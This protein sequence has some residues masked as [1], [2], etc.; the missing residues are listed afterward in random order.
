MGKI[1]VPTLII[2]GELDKVDP[3]SE[4]KSELLS[5]IPHAEMKIIPATGHL[6]PLESPT[7]VAEMIIHFVKKNGW[8][9]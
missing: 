9:G 4:L 1:D 5:R 3:A 7:E 6:S 2:A 8:T